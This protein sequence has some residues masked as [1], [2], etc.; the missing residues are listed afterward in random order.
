MRRFL[1][2]LASASSTLLGCSVDRAPS[3]A[4]AT[5]TDPIINGTPDPGHDAV[6][7]I[8]GGGSECSATV[9]AV[10]GGFGYA[11]TAGHCLS[12]AQFVY[13]GSDY[14]NPT[15]MYKVVKKNVHPAYNAAQ[16]GSPYDFTMIKFQGA[17]ANMATIPPLDAASDMLATGTSVELV[18]YGSTN[19]GQNSQKRH[20]TVPI[21]N[22][23]PLLIGFSGVPGGT[24]QG[25]SGGPAI[26]TIGGQ[27][28]V[29]GVTSYGVKGCTGAGADGRVSPFTDCF[30]NAFIA[31]TP[32]SASC[33][34]VTSIF[35]PETT[36]C[37]NCVTN[38]L[39]G[40]C[41]AQDQPCGAMS[42]TLDCANYSTCTGVCGET[43]TAC[44]KGCAALYPTGST[45]LGALD[46]CIC[47]QAC[48]S[49]CVVECNGPKGTCGFSP[50]DASC[51]SCMET[52]CCAEASAC[53]G[54][55]TCQMCQDASMPVGCD[56]NA[57]S[58]AYNACIAN[59]CSGPC[60]VPPGTGGAGGTGAGGTD[61]GTGGGGAG[62]VDPGTG[63]AGPG[64]GGAA[65]GGTNA[66]G[67]GQGGANAAGTG[68]GG[69]NTAGAGQGGTG[70]GGTVGK[71]GSGTAGQ[72]GSGQGVGGKGQ[73]GSGKAGSA[74]AGVGGNAGSVGKGGAAGAGV[75]G[76]TTA[77]GTSAKG[78]SSTG[79]AGA[80]STG[81]GGASAGAS[82]ND[83][84]TQPASGS[85]G[86][87]AIA[88]PK[89]D[90]SGAAALILVGLAALVRRRKR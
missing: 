62:G 26:V 51:K 36:A 23:G 81:V 2:V 72:A 57:L 66:A 30:I 25:D 86:G 82:Q 14:N 38:S 52:S 60:M 5:R 79:K 28:Y 69:K 83:A 29:A 18:G 40:A 71:G 78:G 17:P 6:V 61:P 84:N 35:P 75:A 39:T 76:G 63:G 88:T 20:V 8:L 34:K 13:T 21:M 67:T 55:P 31:G 33:G 45:Q 50:I 85:S 87:C 27:E 70:T 46:D 73:G 48:P 89:H 15:G 65:Q 24:C 80:S 77:G 64:T 68:Q 74:G 90:R 3:P 16:N 10:Q 42:S 19:Q 4:I 32:L 41:A 49:E 58:N 56:T 53:Y 22:V 7:A 1:L 9:L 59:N 44:F 47:F 12:A 37:S 54:D 11:I 43:D